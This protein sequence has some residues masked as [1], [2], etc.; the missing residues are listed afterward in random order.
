MSIKEKNELEHANR[1]FP[2]SNVTGMAM[3]KPHDMTSAYR[4][5]SFMQPSNRNRFAELY[6]EEVASQ[7]YNR[8]VREEREELSKQIAAAYNFSNQN[9]REKKSAELAAYM[10]FELVRPEILATPFALGAFQAINLGNGDLPLILRPQSRQYFNVNYC[11]IDGSPKQ[12]QW[13]TTKS[14]EQILMRNMSTVKVEYPLRDLQQGDVNEYD[15]I[16]N[17]LRFDMDMKI[18]EQALA[19]IDGAAAEQGLRD[20]IDIHPR[21]DVNNIPDGNYLNLTNSATYGATGTWTLPRLKALL[22]HIN[23][24]SA[25]VTPEGPMAIS[26]IIYSPQNVEDWWSFVDLV[27]GY[28]SSTLEA[29]P[30]NVVPTPVREQIFSTGMMNNA[31]GHSWTSIHNP[32]IPKGTMYVFTNQPIGWFFTKTGYDNLIRWEGPDQVAMNL[33]QVQWSRAF[34]FATVDLWRYRFV[35]VVF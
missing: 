3:P 29:S 27:S 13:R 34:Q 9:T 12:D 16:Q 19:Q 31:W 30:Q 18:D 22:A 14:A 21:I 35:K 6:S 1:M 15:R 4:L 32:I 17:Q 25:G 5:S 33:G 26:S 7:F 23:R 10:E 24:F 28:D 20:T 2:G 8:G 11:A